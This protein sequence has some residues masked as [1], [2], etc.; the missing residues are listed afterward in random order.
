MTIN[1]NEALACVKLLVCVAKAD[2]ELAPEERA[3][4]QDSLASAKLPEGVTADSLLAATYDPDALI[5]EIK[6]ADARDAAYS[7]LFT[8]AYADRKLHPAEQALL[9]K[10]EQAWQVA[11]EKKGLFGRIFQE[12]RDT[13]SLTA[14][15]PIADPAKRE[16]EINE[17]VLKYSILSGALGVFPIPI[18]SIATDLAVIG[19]QGKMVRDIGQYWGRETTKEGVKQLLA[20]MGVGHVGRIA[21]NNLLKFVPVLGSVAAATSNFAST[22]AAGRVANQF[23]ASGGKLDMGTLKDMFKTKESEG[24]KAYEA[25]KAAVEAKAKADKA[26]LDQL[27]AD[28][29]AGKITQAE[30]EQKL[31]ALK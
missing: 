12:A 29:K 13:V 18:A 16:K 10:V 25:N 27:G 4:L 30:Y 7:A 6:T 17:D 11:P 24:R 9:Q 26:K 23:Y 20:G 15:Q 28:Y 31:I 1:Q 22:W 21:F 14:I 8:M 5:A 2:G 19:I 3:S